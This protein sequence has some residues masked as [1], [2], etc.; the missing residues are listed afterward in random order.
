MLSFSLGK[1][2]KEK[3]GKKKPTYVYV[4]NDQPN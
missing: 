1:K 2:G 4:Y 3:G